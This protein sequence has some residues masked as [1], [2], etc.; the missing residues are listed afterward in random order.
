MQPLVSQQQAILAVAG[1]YLEAGQQAEHSG[2]FLRLSTLLVAHLAATRVI[3][4][5]V[6]FPVFPGFRFCETYFNRSS[7]GKQV[8]I[9]C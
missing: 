2:T 5:P 1:K 9:V 8:V 6:S 3:S 4:P 7:A